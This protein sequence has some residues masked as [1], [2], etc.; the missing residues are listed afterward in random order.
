MRS[1]GGER[2][3]RSEGRREIG[4]DRWWD[5]SNIAESSERGARSAPDMTE[6]VTFVEEKVQAVLVVKEV[7]AA[8]AVKEVSEVKELR[9]MKEVPGVT[10]VRA[11]K[12]V[13]EVEDVRE[14]KEAAI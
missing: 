4:K 14:A 9:G 13:R 10:Q 6:D 8:A 2:G 5:S 7:S 1:E 12:T 3:E 11:V